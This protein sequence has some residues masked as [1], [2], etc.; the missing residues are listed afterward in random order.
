[1]K[2]LIHEEHKYQKVKSNEDENLCVTVT[3]SRVYLT[4]IN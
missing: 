1:M 3:T 2:K 4:H